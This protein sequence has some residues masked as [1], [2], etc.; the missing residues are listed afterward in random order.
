MIISYTP[1]HTL[2][3]S[4]YYFCA[5]APFSLPSQHTNIHRPSDEISFTN[6]IMIFGLTQTQI[7]MQRKPKANQM[8]NKKRNRK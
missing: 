1:T 5:G 2:L 6:S 3:I 4:P 7:I 8:N